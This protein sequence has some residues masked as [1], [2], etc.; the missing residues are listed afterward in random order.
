MCGD[1]LRAVPN[2]GSQVPFDSLVIPSS[3]IRF[4]PIYFSIKR[5]PVVHKRSYARFL[6]LSVHVEI[7]M[8]QRSCNAR[9]YPMPL[10]QTMAATAGLSIFREA[11]GRALCE[12]DDD[13]VSALK[14]TADARSHTPFY[15]TMNST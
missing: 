5:S 6:W 3:Y 7:D 14:E 12:L 8:A 10:E 15:K 1:T 2:H 4:L 13:T 9:V 11:E